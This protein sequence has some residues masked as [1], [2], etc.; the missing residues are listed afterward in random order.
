M[1]RPRV[2]AAVRTDLWRQMAESGLSAESRLLFVHLA[3]APDISPAGVTAMTPARWSHLTGLAPRS[4]G[5]ALEELEA[6][7]YVLADHD[8]SEVLVVEFRVWNPP[9]SYLTSSDLC[10]GIT[11][12]V[13]RDRVKRPGRRR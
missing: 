12:S 8:T 5:A 10:D 13:I 7:S 2:A 9:P 1:I 3:T 6:S 4:V 11:S